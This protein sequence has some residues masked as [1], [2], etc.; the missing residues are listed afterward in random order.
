MLGNSPSEFMFRV[1]TVC[2]DSVT[3]FTY[4]SKGAQWLN[5]RVLDPRSRG[6]RFEPHGCHCVV[7][8]ARHINP[9]LVLV[10]PRKTRPYITVRL[11]MGRKES[12]QTK[13]MGL[14]AR[15][16]VFWGLR[17]TKGQTSLLITEYMVVK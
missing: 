3:Y 11:L 9:S 1:Y 6:C 2:S 12:K 13:N 5:H 8:L 10:Q 17:T 14:D 16:P 15:K 4:Y 7:P